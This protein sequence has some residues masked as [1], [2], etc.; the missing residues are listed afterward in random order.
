M[1]HLTNDRTAPYRAS[2]KTAG[3]RMLSE[4]FV[5][6]HTNEVARKQQNRDDLPQSPVEQGFRLVIIQ[7]S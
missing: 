6:D 3:E 2:V 7:T 5:F 4:S 1:P